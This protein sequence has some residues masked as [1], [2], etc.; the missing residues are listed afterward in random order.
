MIFS[1]RQLSSGLAALVAAA[2]YLCF[3][4]SAC[5]EDGGESAEASDSGLVDTFPIDASG[6]DPDTGLVGNAPRLTF[7]NAAHDLGNGA[8]IANAPDKGAVRLCFKQ[9]SLAQNLTIAPYPPLPTRAVGGEPGD[10]PGV[11]YGSGVTL[12]TAGLDLAGRIIVPI[13]MNENSLLVRNVDN[14]QPGQRPKTCE[15][16]LAV[17]EG[18]GLTENLDYW[19]L[20]PISVGTLANEKTYVAALTGCV[21]IAST[22]NPG[23]CGP[24]F[25]RVN[26]ENLPTAGNLKLSFYET[27]RVPV[28]APFGA[29]FLYLS[30]QANAYFSQ[31]AAKN[32]IRPGFVASASDGS[33]FR[34]ISD[35]SPAARVLQDV[36][37]VTNVL[38]TDSFVL[39]PKSLNGAEALKGIPL[40][41]S[42]LTTIQ[43][44][45]GLVTPYEGGRNYVF[46]AVGDPDANEAKPFLKRD[47]TSAGEGGAGA[48]FNTRAF[49]FLAFPTDPVVSP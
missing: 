7:V 44:L 48:H 8:A 35:L 22:P 2:A 36:V 5:S 23:K 1:P 47:G 15:E 37:P 41:P 27:T 6:G 28:A 31:S 13:V 42:S 18:L 34:P 11:Y 12:A 38:S 16:L 25:V 19:V 24:G 32:A 30:T 49:H 46:I 9:G 14:L 26:E 10:P 21:G 43:T 4:S 39:G 40:L 3:A 29:Q 45:S 17:D 33:G 20:P